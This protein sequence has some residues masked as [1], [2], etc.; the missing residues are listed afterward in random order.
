MNNIVFDRRPKEVPAVQAKRVAAGN[1]ITLV[2]WAD[3][4]REGAI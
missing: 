1:V 4:P 3:R 2:D